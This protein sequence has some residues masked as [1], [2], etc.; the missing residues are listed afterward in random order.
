MARRSASYGIF[1]WRVIGGVLVTASL[2]LMLTLLPLLVTRSRS[3]APGNAT[4]VLTLVAANT[5]TPTPL[6][7][8]A[9]QTPGSGTVAPTPPPGV[10]SVG[11][12]VQVVGTQGDG[13]RL[14]DQPGLAG[15]VLMLG[16]EAEVFR[17]DQG[18]QEVDGYTWWYLVGPFDPNRKG[19]A[20]ANYLQVVQGQ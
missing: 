5:S 16:S 6:E 7:T 17:V 11:A 4:V 10:V 18:P 15:Q 2:L 20:V 8:G 3:A 1:T 19:W 13:L 14:R 12:F 9:A